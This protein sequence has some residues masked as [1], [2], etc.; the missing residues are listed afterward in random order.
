VVQ[1]DGREREGEGEIDGG[2]EGAFQTFQLGT[3]LNWWENSRILL[4]YRRVGPGQPN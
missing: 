4:K 1:G 3:S 2:G